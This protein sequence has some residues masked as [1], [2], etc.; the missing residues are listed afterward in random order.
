MKKNSENIIV[1][2][3]KPE[4]KYVKVYHDFLDNSILTGGEQTVFIALKSYIDFREDSGEAYPSMETICKRAKMS[5]KRARKNINLLVNKGIVEKVRR[6]L[7]KTNLYKLSDYDSMWSCDNV[8]DV[9]EIV[10]N[11]GVKPMTVEEHIAALKNMGYDVE[12]K[13]KGLVSKPTKVNS[14][15]PHHINHLPE[16][17]SMITPDCQAEAD[18]CTVEQE[19]PLSVEQTEPCQA[20]SHD[21]EQTEQDPTDRYGMDELKQKYCYDTLIFDYPHDKEAIDAV[22]DIIHKTVNSGKRVIRVDSEDRPA[23]EVKERL[24]DLSSEEI[25]YI[26]DK[27]REQ[28][29]RIRNPVAYLLTLLY[30]S[31]IQMQLDITNH[32]RYCA[33]GG[34]ELFTG[35]GAV[36]RPDVQAGQHAAGPEGQA[37]QQKQREQHAKKPA[38]RQPDRPRTIEQLKEHFHYD[39]LVN[40]ERLDPKDVDAVMNAVYGIANTDRDLLKISGQFV[41]TTDIMDRLM[42]LSREEIIFAI[43]KYKEQNGRKDLSDLLYGDTGGV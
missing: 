3:A 24:L 6:G 1:R 12:I 28:T 26:V 42:N 20:A 10:Q 4:R 41:F 5:E 19:N 36:I 16:D 30:K 37:E 38:E 27:Y 22:L 9:A 23:L 18:N 25:K 15:D 39:V 21:T 7:T 40:D 34:T 11:D 31:K 33:A 14:Q 32:I 2:L 35:N 8:E 43:K 13:E 29:G 17:H